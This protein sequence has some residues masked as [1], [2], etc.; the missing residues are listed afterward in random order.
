M[1][2]PQ[3]QTIQPR[4]TQSQAAT[5]LLIRH[6]R[7]AHN[8]AGKIQ[9]RSEVP[10][11]EE[12]QAQARQLADHLADQFRSGQLARP[13]SQIW[14]SDLTRAQQTAGAVAGALGTAVV[15][16][17]RL[18]EQSFGDYKGRL[19]SELLAENSVFEQAWTQDFGALHP[20]GGESFAETT[21]RTMAWFGDA[22]PRRGGELVIAVSHGLTLSALLCALSGLSP[23]EAMRRGLFRHG[24]TAYTIVSLDPET[25]QMREYSAVQAGH[26]TASPPQ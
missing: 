24:N 17:A 8:R 14:A 23:R 9:G 11:D 16:D 21:A 20:P 10:L 7:T 5:L 6:G 12:S 1:S 22:R 25:G 26:L 13:P 3:L 4:T 15:T 18:R 2:G 19:L